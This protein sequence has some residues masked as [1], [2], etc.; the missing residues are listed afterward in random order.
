MFWYYYTLFGLPPEADTETKVSVQVIYL[1]SHTFGIYNSF[2][3]QLTRRPVGK[4]TREGK[5]AKAVYIIK[6]AITMGAWGL[7]SLGS[8]GASVD[9]PQCYR[10]KG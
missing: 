9:A 5:A 3:R 6:P 8:L 2:G 4:Q 1:G 7:I 10:P